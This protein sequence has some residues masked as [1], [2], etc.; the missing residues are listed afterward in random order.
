VTLWRNIFRDDGPVFG[1]LALTALASQISVAIS[2]ILLGVALLIAL[3]RIALRRDRP[4]ATGVELPG[5]LF[6]GWALLMIPFSTDPGG[7]LIL[8]KRFYLFT[9]LW[10]CAWYVR[11]EGRRAVLLAALLFGAVFNCVYTIVTQSWLPGDFAHRIS[12]MQHSIISGSWLVMSAALIALALVLHGRGRWPRGLAAGT[13]L[14]LLAA[15]MLTQS[16]SAW[17][18]F[19]AGAVV[20]LALRRRRLVLVMAAIGVL[21]FALGPDVF[22]DRLKTIIDPKFRTNVQRFQMWDAG[23]DLIKANP[24]T[25]VGDCNLRE[26]CPDLHY[27]G[28]RGRVTRLAHFHSNYIM[29]AVIWGIPGLALGLWFL[30]ALAARFWRRFRLYGGV[31]GRG[32]PNRRVWLVAALGVWVAVIVTGIFDWSFGDP[33]LSLVIFMT[34]GAALSLD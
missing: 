14:P 23:V 27:Q 3:V 26:F 5:L 17:L 13:L 9:A 7:S 18:G 34:F 24:V 16:R 33:E 8:A 21:F 11:G 15:L 25:G 19:T 12:M 10:L 31:T 2:Q 29:M 28:D 30:I 1:A 20:V 6:V 4:G 22:R 32:P